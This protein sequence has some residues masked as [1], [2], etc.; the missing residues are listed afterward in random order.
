[1]TKLRPVLLILV[2]LMIVCT[3]PIILFSD[4]RQSMIA[5]LVAGESGIEFSYRFAALI[6]GLFSLDILLPVPASVLCAVAGR[7]FG[8]AIG[9][10]LC[11]AGLNIAAAIGFYGARMLGWPLAK[12]FSTECDLR[13]VAN[14]LDRFGVWPLVVLRPVPVLAEASVLLL[15]AY[16]YPQGKFWPAVIGANLLMALVFV[17]LGD[18]FEKS[19]QF[20][21]GLLISSLMPLLLLVVFRLVLSSSNE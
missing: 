21:I 13:I 10:L 8:V 6:V 9:T 12:R 17:A 3:I 16:R 11:W 5:E 14:Q 19:G 4:Q 18:W 20:W 15:G 7:T 2:S 1:M